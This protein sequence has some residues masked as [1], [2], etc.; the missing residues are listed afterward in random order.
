M[1]MGLQCRAA[2]FALGV[3][4]LVLGPIQETA[5]AMTTPCHRT[6][7]PTKRIVGGSE[8][9]HFGFNYTDWAIQ[10]G[11]FYHKDTLVFMYDPP[12]NKTPP[13]SV[14]LLRNLRSFLACDLKKAKL[15]ANEVQGGGTGFKFVLKKR[16]NYFFACGERGGIHCSLGL[17]KFFVRPKR[18]CHG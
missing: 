9:W 8:H 3:I 2:G 16:K 14:Y 4:L 5:Q 15:A 11:P 13:H 12:E 18:H 7:G 10:A 17:M 6:Y 1:K